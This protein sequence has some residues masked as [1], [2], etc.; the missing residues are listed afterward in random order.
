MTRQESPLSPLTQP[1]MGTSLDRC[2]LQS[3]ISVSLTH[4]GNHLQTIQFLSFQLGLWFWAWFG[5]DSTTLILM[6]LNQ[7]FWTLLSTFCHFHFLHSAVPLSKQPVSALPKSPELGTVPCQY[8][9]LAYVFSKERALSVCPQRPCDCSNGLSL[10]GSST[11]S[12]TTIGRWW[13]NISAISLRA[14]TFLFFCNNY[15][16][17]HLLKSI[18][19]PC[20][21]SK[22]NLY[23]VVQFKNGDD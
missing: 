13:R 22:L 6:W 15:Q 10:V 3:L 20:C 14:L 12:P 5:C 1:K 2:W 21:F 7:Q 8:H 11:I 19:V 18:I 16:Y 4:S 23:D 17:H 9:D